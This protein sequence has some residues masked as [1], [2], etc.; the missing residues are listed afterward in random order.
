M[1]EPAVEK[2]ITL[3]N[4]DDG[5]DCLHIRKLQDLHNKEKQKLIFFIF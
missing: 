1:L 4:S 5:H 3:K 2:Y